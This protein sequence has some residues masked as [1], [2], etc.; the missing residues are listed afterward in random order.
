L[1]FVFKG[2]IITENLQTSG[3]TLNITQKEKTQKHATGKMHFFGSNQVAKSL[4][5]TI[6]A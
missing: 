6:L 4:E 2:L 3:Y 5:Y 1:R